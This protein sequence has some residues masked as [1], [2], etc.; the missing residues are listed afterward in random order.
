MTDQARVAVR[1]AV[2]VAIGIALLAAA[3]GYFYR[4][5]FVA[6]GSL[7]RGVARELALRAAGPAQTYRVPLPASGG[8]SMPMVPVPFTTMNAQPHLE[9]G[10]WRTNDLGLA[11]PLNFAEQVE[12]A[13]QIHAAGGRV[14][15]FTGGS[16]LLPR[17][18]SVDSLPNMVAA[19]LERDHLNVGVFNYGM[20]PWTSTEE[21]AAILH[22]AADLQP[23]VIVAHDG[24]N[25]LTRC[26][27]A[28]RNRNRKVPFAFDALRDSYGVSYA[29]AYLDHPLTEDECGGVVDDYRQ[30]LE[31]IG[32][33]MRSR[34]GVLIVAPQPV[35][36]VSNDAP[37]PADAAQLK[38][39]RRYHDIVSAANE[40]GR[41]SSVRVLDTSVVFGKARGSQQ[42]FDDVRTLTDAG[43]R[44][45]A[46]QIAAA[47]KPILAAKAPADGVRR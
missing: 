12:R 8:A 30:N 25:D 4:F 36:S 41:R 45:V 24:Y 6:R 17:R 46:G 10:G 43:R 38:I 44:I 33:L 16:S 37:A 3:H 20:E 9:Q 40:I 23:D 26:F 7:A 34:A 29:S 18:A 1:T 31:I 14:V 5:T 27:V 28:G 11:D 15:V 32:D 2:V 22:W 35:Q 13:R 42:Y 19:L 39:A 21:L 47:L